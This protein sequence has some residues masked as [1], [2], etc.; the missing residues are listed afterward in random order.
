M[1]EKNRTFKQLQKEKR[2]EELN[3]FSKKVTETYALSPQEYS[4]TNAAADNQL[5]KKGLRDVMDYAIVTALVTRDVATKVLEKTIKNQQRKVQ[6]AGSSSLSH[7]KKIIRLR[8][9]Y[10]A[11]GYS[12]VE[13]GKITSN[14]ATSNKPISYYT[15]KYETES[16]D[17]TRLLLERAIAENIASDDEMEA[18]IARSLKVKSTDSVKLY[19]QNLRSKREKNKKESSQ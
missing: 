15:Q 17:V 3:D 7:H 11:D 6:D 16:D 9:K 12:R 13:I 1:S 5:T 8:E 19:F 10:L 14:F 2:L 18:I 4:Q